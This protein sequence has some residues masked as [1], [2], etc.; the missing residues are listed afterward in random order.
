[1]GGVAPR[2]DFFGI[3][4]VCSARTARPGGAGQDD[5]GHTLFRFRGAVGATLSPG[6]GRPDCPRQASWR[7][8]FVT[9]FLNVPSL[10]AGVFGFKGLGWL[11]TFMPAVVWGLFRLRRATCCSRLRPAG[12][13]GY[14]PT[15]SVVV[16]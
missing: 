14:R 13:G 12:A 3:F 8:L 10:W 4:V 7:H 16:G 15:V 1:M 2:R 5:Y 6:H 9:N 11:D